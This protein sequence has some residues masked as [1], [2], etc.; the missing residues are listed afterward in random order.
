MSRLEG[1]VVLV[2]GGA[3][4]IGAAIARAA[5]AEGAKVVIGDVLG[6]GRRGAGDGARRVCEVRPPRRHEAGRLGSG[7]RDRR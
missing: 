5:V 3:R 6:P 2:T 1:K 4:G 7:D